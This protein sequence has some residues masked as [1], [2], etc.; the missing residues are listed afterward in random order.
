MS[1][2]RLISKEELVIS[3][4]G[5]TIRFRRFLI[6]VLLFQTVFITHPMVVV[7]VAA[8]P[9]LVDSFYSGLITETGQDFVMLH[10]DVNMSAHLMPDSQ[11]ED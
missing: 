1:K 3:S 11:D 6:L 2:T 9:S 7:S 4:G 10:A 8:P 5:F